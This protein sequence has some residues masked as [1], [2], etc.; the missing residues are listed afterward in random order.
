MLEL[1]SHFMSRCKESQITRSSMNKI[2]RRPGIAVRHCRR[3]NE[4]CPVKNQVS[5][6]TSLLS[7]L[8]NTFACWTVLFHKLPAP[9]ALPRCRCSAK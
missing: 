5:R 1:T 4:E 2:D 3:K 8:S 7:Q 9:P 6:A